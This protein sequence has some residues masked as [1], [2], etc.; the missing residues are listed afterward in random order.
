MPLLSLI[1]AVHDEQ[2]YIA[3]CA[4][5]ILGQDLA[6]VELIAIDDASSD[7]GPAL[8]DELAERDARVTVRHLAQP[9]G[10]GDARNLGLDLA[11]GDYVWFVSTT[12]RL[13]Q[14]SLARVAEQLRSGS[15]DVLVVNHSTKDMLGRSRQGPHRKALARAAKDGP[16]S[17]EQ[18]P[19]LADAA[20]QAWNKV[21]RRGLLTDL[22]TRF[23]SGANSELTVTWPALLSADRIAALPAQSY[24]RRL[25]ANANPEAG[26]ASDVF[27]QYD[28]ALAFAGERRELVASAML[29]HLLALLDRVPEPD[30]RDFFHR[31]SETYKRHGGTATGRTAQLV[32]ADRY[33]AFQAFQRALETRRSLSRSRARLRKRAGRAAGKARKARLERHYRAQ[34]RRP[35]DPDLAVFAAYWYSAYSCNPRAIYEKARELV[36]GMRGVWIV[37]PEA[38]DALPAGVE[39]VLAG[40]REYYETIARARYLVNNVN[41]P[42]HVVKREGS[43]HV[44]T[45]HGTP[46]KRMGLDQRDAPVSGAR[47]DFPGLMRRCSRW[48]FSVSANPF[49]TLVWEHA[50]PFPYESLEVGYPRNDVLATATDEDVRRI[51]ADLGIP[52][53]QTV[54]LYAPTHREYHDSYVPSLDLEAVATALGPECLVLSRAHYFYEDAGPRDGRVRDVSDHPSVEE[55]MLAANVLV[56]DYSSIMFDYAVL[57]RPIVVHAPDWDVYRTLRGTYFDLMNEAPGPVTKAEAEVVDAVRSG[58][59]AAEARAAFRARFCSLEDGRAAERVVRRVWFGERVPAEGREQ[60]VVG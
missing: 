51:R 41:F 40:T 50:Y 33:A 52:P 49:S 19:A 43:V 3:D 20:P 53:G 9:V 45:H 34:L 32:A 48:D 37:K 55:L 31:M 21:L 22:G 11:S 29:R 14:G 26:S 25:R 24:E 44:M 46:L 2:A 54:V 16:G 8:L 30:R 15:P 13:P 60:A 57:D 47:I 28:A 38:V 4:E 12:D 58:D 1:L 27:E 39:H 56:T 5:S 42:N 23:G 7:H 6:D 10:R 36:P 35:I 17:L 59:R 18:H